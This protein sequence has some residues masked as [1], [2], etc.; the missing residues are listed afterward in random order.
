MQKRWTINPHG[1][2]TA[3]PLELA[4][5]LERYRANPR[6]G[7]RK[8]LVHAVNREVGKALA[9]RGAAKK[10][11]LR[12]LAHYEDHIPG[13]RMPEAAHAVLDTVK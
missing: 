6:P 1:G 9:L 12:G 5:R 2:A 3:D 10:A 8:R 13:Y 7:L 11:K 4:V